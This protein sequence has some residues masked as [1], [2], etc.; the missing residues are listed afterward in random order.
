[1]F[2]SNRPAERRSATAHAPG[3]KTPPSRSWPG[4]P[5]HRF[6]QRAPSLLASAIE[7]FPADVTRTSRD[8]RPL[9]PRP[10]QQDR[11]RAAG[12]LATTRY[13][14]EDRASAPSAAGSNA[15]V[16]GIAGDPIIDI[17]RKR[18]SRSLPSRSLCI[19]TARTCIVDADATFS[20]ASPE[21]ACAFALENVE[22]SRTS[23]A[24]IGVP[25]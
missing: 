19:S 7:K 10:C 9:A 16:I 14:R 4:R 5:H 21:N 3:R 17:V 8:H 23:A 24:P 11:S 18:N 20:T 2:G 15:D 13:G 25:M 12:N 6:V 22:N 1:M